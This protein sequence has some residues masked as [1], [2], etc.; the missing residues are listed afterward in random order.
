MEIDEPNGPKRKASTPIT[1]DWDQ[2]L[3]REDGGD[4]RP[5][6]LEVIRSNKKPKELSENIYQSEDLEMVVK[7]DRELKES[8][9]RFK[10]NLKTL[11]H[12]LRDGGERLRVSLKRHEDELER[13]LQRQLMNKVDNECA[14]MIQVSDSDDGVSRGQKQGDRKSL[15]SPS[16]TKLF[17]KKLEDPEDLKDSRTVNA[18]EEELFYIKP[19]NGRRGRPNNQVAAKGRSRMALSSSSE[20]PSRSSKSGLV[21]CEKQTTSNDDKPTSSFSVPNSPQGPPSSNLRP[22]TRRYYNVVEE[23]PPV[24]TTAQFLEELDPCVKDAT[25]YYPS[26]DDPDAVEVNHADMGCLAPE[27]YL[28]STIM[29]FYIRYLQ[30]P[31]SSSESTTCNYHFFSTYFYNKLEKLKYEEDSFRK[32]RKWWKDVSIF[33]KAYI[34]LPVHES[35]HWS[36]VIICFPTKEDEQG[37]I[38]LHLDSLGLHNSKLICDNIKRF[39]KEEWSY[40]RKSG[41]RLDLPISD[42]I[43]ENLES[44]MEHKRVTVPQQK[45]EYDCGLFVLFYMERFIK[46]APER[47]KK[48]DLSMFRRQWF[49]PQEASNLRPA[50]CNLLVEEFRKVKEKESTPLSQLLD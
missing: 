42:E 40:L 6:E 12:K 19:C 1:L 18:F 50:I 43:W 15:S 25:L 5:P 16:F 10:R 32:F 26:R 35:A 21:D 41:T 9:A 27:A 13:R 23:D 38:L 8:I 30:Q 7:S 36:L 22:R 24:Q 44:K 47:I 39:L 33:E 48:K 2:L 31:T 20:E 34:L 29:N 28:S 14:E 11:A 4:D 3:S 37:P 17:D 46:Q 49:Q 45:N